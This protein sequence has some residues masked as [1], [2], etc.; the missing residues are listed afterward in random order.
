MTPEEADAKPFPLSESHPNLIASIG[1]VSLIPAFSMPP[2]LPLSHIWV[3]LS[4]ILLQSWNCFHSGGEYCIGFYMLHQARKFPL[5]AEDSTLIC[6]SLISLFIKTTYSVPFA[7]SPVSSA[8]H[9]TMA[10]HQSSSRATT[11]PRSE[12]TASESSSAKRRRQA[13][14]LRTHRN[15]KR[16]EKEE[17]EQLYQKNENRIQ[18]LERMVHD[19]SSELRNKK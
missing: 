10:K 2:W 12:S 17:M 16:S 15:K 7:T 19:L 4:S 3:P 14:N 18:S 6:Y 8:S 11:E 5:V 9:I 1:I 13:E